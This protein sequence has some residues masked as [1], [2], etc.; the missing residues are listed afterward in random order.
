MALVLFGSI[1]NALDVILH[2]L[3]FEVVE[4]LFHQLLLSRHEL[5][6]GLPHDYI[7]KLD[8]AFI[9]ELT[10]IDKLIWTICINRAVVVFFF[11]KGDFFAGEV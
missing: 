10:R 11:F 4:P 5:S 7:A 6:V 3:L 1:V 2:V 9:R 8:K